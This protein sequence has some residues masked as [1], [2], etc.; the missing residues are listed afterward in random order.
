[1]NNNHIFISHSSKDDDFVKDLRELLEGHGLTVWADS[2]NLRAGA[3]LAPEIEQAIGQARQF[4]AIIS[5]RAINSP[6]CA[7]KFKRRFSVFVDSELPVGASE[8]EQAL[9]QYVFFKK[10]T[11]GH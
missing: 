4:I 8:Q 10:S 11:T 5:P 3:E 7:K 6:G 1:M 9:A 2:R